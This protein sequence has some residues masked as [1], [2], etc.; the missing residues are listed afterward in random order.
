MIM[1]RYALSL[2]ILL[3]LGMVARIGLALSP[4]RGAA[5]AEAALS[6]PPVHAGELAQQSDASN[7]VS[8][9]GTAEA[10]V[11]PGA[12]G[13]NVTAAELDVLSHLRGLKAKLDQRAK[14]LDAREK[15]AEAAEATAAARIVQLQ[16]LEA[17]I[18]SALQQEQKLKSK[19]IK[20]LAAVYDTM[21]PA[22]AAPMIELMDMPTTVKLL[23]RMDQKR[24]GKILSFMPPE[25]AMQISEALTERIASLQGK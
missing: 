7:P 12:P 17:S 23:S 13:Q 24:V 2:M 4:Q 11:F 5:P 8:L 1:R 3:T 10:S 25:K 18:Q 16:K 21:K 22:K 20:K 9:I 15:A 6:V 19:K 14:D